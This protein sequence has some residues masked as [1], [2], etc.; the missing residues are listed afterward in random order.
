MA[1]TALPT[2]TEFCK[3]A[4]LKGA[5]PVNAPDHSNLGKMASFQRKGLLARF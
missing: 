1:F 3:D 2:V 4:L 5:Q